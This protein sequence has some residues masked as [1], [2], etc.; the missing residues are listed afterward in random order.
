MA[1]RRGSK[2]DT[3]E[4]LAALPSRAGEVDNDA[5]LAHDAVFG[6]MTGKGPNYRDVRIP[7]LTV[8]LISTLTKGEMSRSDGSARPPS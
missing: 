5:T 8:P 1:T 3:E 4:G 6:N 7:Y 2:Q